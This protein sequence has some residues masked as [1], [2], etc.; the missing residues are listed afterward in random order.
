MGS[1]L[2]IFILPILFSKLSIYKNDYIEYILKILY[3][4]SFNSIYFFINTLIWF[5]Y[6][7]NKENYQITFAL[8]VNK[9]N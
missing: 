6:L 5:N 9:E 4:S 7:E 8:L 1:A 2:I 3:K